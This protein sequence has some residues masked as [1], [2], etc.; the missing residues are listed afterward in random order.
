MENFGMS[1]V[2]TSSSATGELVNKKIT[3][4]RTHSVTFSDK[5]NIVSGWEKY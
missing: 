1:D 4:F 3:Q 2:E 5:Q